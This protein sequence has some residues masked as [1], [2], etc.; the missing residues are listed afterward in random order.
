M[1][2]FIIVFRIKKKKNA[3]KIIGF[4]NEFQEFLGTEAECSAS[5]YD[6]LRC[7]VSSECKTT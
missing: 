5:N 4:K 3:M 6:L 2:H 7:M 1:N